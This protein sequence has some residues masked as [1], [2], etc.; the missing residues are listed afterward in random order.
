MDSL[1]HI[2]MGTGISILALSSGAIDNEYST[3]TYCSII[4]ASVIPDID[5]ISKLFGNKTYINNHR[6]FTHSIVMFFILSFILNLITNYF[7]PQNMHN[8]L[9]WWILLSVGLHLLTDIFNNYGI[10]L[11]WPLKDKWLY[12]GATHTIDYIIL[13]TFTIGIILYFLFNINGT[14]YFILALILTVIYLLIL[15]LRREFRI[16]QIKSNFNDAKRIFLTSKAS[17]NQWKFVVQTYNGIYHIGELRGKSLIVLQSQ[18][19]QRTIEQDLYDN[20]KNDKNLQIFL[21]FSKV[22]NWDIKKR[23]RITEIRIKDLTYYTRINKKYIYL[24]NCVIYVNNF[25]KKIENTYVGFTT[26]DESLYKML[27]HPISIKNIHK[28][29]FKNRGRID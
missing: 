29:L 11:L 18:K 4:T 5:V 6:G 28:I 10:K 25:T 1:S 23:E 16:M 3:L 21:K 15:T 9:L 2:S 24:F 19:K 8:I 13:S 22:Y 14:V 26:G 7:L 17:P 12:I 27:E 20:I